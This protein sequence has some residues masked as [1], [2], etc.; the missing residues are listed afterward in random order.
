MPAT[1][2]VIGN[3]LILC[4]YRLLEDDLVRLLY[5][6]LMSVADPWGQWPPNWCTF[7]LYTTKMCKIV[8]KICTKLN[9][10]CSTYLLPPRCNTSESKFAAVSDWETCVNLSM[11]RQLRCSVMCYCAGLSTSCDCL[12]HSA[13][14]RC[15]AG[16]RR[17]CQ[18]YQTELQ[19][20]TSSC[21]ASFPRFS[22]PSW[23]AHTGVFLLFY[24]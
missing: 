19:L 8:T 14:P 21:S 3:C 20:E 1:V 24:L 18:K 23:N 15:I 10:R 12:V 13:L 6:T 7:R 11:G 22:A 16:S 4:Y 5:S 2:C 17:V 9:L